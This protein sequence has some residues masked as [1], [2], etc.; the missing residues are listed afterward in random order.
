[1]ARDRFSWGLECQKCGHTGTVYISEN[2]GWAY[3][4]GDRDRE[5]TKITDGFVVIDPGRNMHEETVINCSCGS[6]ARFTRG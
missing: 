4:R 6:V 3:V 5:I 1:M 2:D